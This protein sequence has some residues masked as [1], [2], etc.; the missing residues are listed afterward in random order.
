M[1][2]RDWF[3]NRWNQ[4]P[5]TNTNYLSSE[6]SGSIQAYWRVRKKHSGKLNIFPGH[7]KILIII[8]RMVSHFSENS[9]AKKRYD[10][11]DFKCDGLMPARTENY[12][13]QKLTWA[14][15]KDYVWRFY[16]WQALNGSDEFIK[17]ISFA[18][19]TAETKNKN[20]GNR[21]PNVIVREGQKSVRI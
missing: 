4:I 1:P 11:A 16:C 17:W 14:I 7:E 13:Q 18:C 19:F 3:S 20:C 12:Q 6:I 2:I 10:Y 5:L 9:Y 21:S 8:A 15:R